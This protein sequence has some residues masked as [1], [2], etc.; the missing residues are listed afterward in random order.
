MTVRKAPVSAMGRDREWGYRAAIS[1]IS[2]PAPLRARRPNPLS[3]PLTAVG[4]GIELI[5]D[6][7]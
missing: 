3:P 4:K 2:H 1:R 7:S 6:G 5:A